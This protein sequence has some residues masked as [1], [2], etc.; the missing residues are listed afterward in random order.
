M[1]ETC[2]FSLFQCPRCDGWLPCDSL[3]R[4]ASASLRVGVLKLI[5]SPGGTRPS[6]QGGIGEYGETPRVYVNSD[7]SVFGL[8]I[9]EIATLHLWTG[10]AFHNYREATR[11]IS[12]LKDTKLCCENKPKN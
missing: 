6:G 4:L 10:I 11:C 5:V 8:L 2:I 3:V 1:E 7:L 9:L 12:Q